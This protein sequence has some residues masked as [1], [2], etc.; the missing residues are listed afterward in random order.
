VA[1]KIPKTLNPN[2]TTAKPSGM[3]IVR[4]KHKQASRSTNQSK[5][6]VR[7]S[8]SPVRSISKSGS[9]KQMYW[10]EHTKKIDDSY[11]QMLIRQNYKN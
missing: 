4:E 11:N 10:N 3:T 1:F 8:I 7:K 2:K 5:S 6:P 9:N